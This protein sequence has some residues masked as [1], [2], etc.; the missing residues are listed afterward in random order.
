[1]YTKTLPIRILPNGETV[2]DWLPT[3]FSDFII[4]YIYSKEER[5]RALM[6]G[7]QKIWCG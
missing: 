3:E 1:M 7:N 4:K 6:F 5:E 2:V